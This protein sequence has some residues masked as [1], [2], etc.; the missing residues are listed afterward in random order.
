MSDSDNVGDVGEIKQV[1]KRQRRFTNIELH[2]NSVTDIMEKSL[3]PTIK[4]KKIRIDSVKDLELSYPPTST[5]Q[6]TIQTSSRSRSN[7]MTLSHAD[8]L[9]AVSQMNITTPKA[10]N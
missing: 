5:T 2:N 8:A 6:P 7:Y 10:V 9:S 4:I 1:H 3:P